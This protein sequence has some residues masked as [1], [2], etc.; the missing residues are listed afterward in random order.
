MCHQGQPGCPCWSGR[1][2]R[3]A[4]RSR[5]RSRVPGGRW[6]RV[7]HWTDLVRQRR[8]GHV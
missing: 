7:H 3:Q 2:H 8:P 5:P 1:G 6:V 4:R